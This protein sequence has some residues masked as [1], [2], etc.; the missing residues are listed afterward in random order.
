LAAAR[1]HTKDRKHNYNSKKNQHEAHKF[2][3]KAQIRGK[4]C[5]AKACG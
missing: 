3:A 1:E 5:K 2:F 4:R